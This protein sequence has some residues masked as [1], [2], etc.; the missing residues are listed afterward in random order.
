MDE[1]AS[2]MSAVGDVAAEIASLEAELV[3][4]RDRAVAVDDARVAAKKTQT[5]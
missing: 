5:R 3:D 4:V 2:E 1:I